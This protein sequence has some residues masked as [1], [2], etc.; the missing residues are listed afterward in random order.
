MQHPIAHPV[1]ITFIVE[2]EAKFK[3]E[4]EAAVNEVKAKKMSN[5]INMIPSFAY[6]IV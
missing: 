1:D 2:K 6:I 3:T 5:W 4:V